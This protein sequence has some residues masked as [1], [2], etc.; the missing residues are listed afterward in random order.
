MH[1]TCEDTYKLKIKEC[2]KMLHANG[3]QK[4]ARI[5]ILTSDKTDFM[6]KAVRRNEGY[7]MMINQFSQRIYQF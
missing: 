7:S 2:K 1:L 4:Q 5:A 6:S 3:N